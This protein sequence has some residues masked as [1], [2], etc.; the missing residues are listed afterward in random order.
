[1][2]TREQNTAIVSLDTLPPSTREAALRLLVELALD[3][4]RFQRTGS[5]KARE[6]T[7]RVLREF[8]N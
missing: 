5:T 8:M 1:M 6:F 2:T 4:Q 7:E 3:E